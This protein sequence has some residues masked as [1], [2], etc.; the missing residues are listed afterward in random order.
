MARLVGLQA[1]TPNAPYIG[2]WTR[3]YGFARADLADLIA[4]REVVRATLLRS[5]L[6]LTTAADYLLFRPALQPALT[7]ALHATFRQRARQLDLGRLLPAALSYLEAAPRRLTALRVWSA[8]LMPTE[9]AEA[10]VSAVARAYLPLVQVF[11]GGVW[12]RATGAYAPAE[13]W[14]GAALAALEEGVRQLILRHLAAFGP[15]S[16]ADVEQWSG[17]RQLGRPLA[18]LGPA[19]REFRD[20]R[21]VA[22]FDLPDA[23]RLPAT[24]PAPPRFLPEYDNLLLAHVDRTRVVADEQRPRIFLSARGFARHSWSMAS[25]AALGASSA[26]TARSPS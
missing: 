8:E 3:L 14:L 23:P 25:C 15:A 13:S 6:H 12:G 26:A 18:A 2:L 17:L 5:T 11:P 16:V 20:E 10:M 9:D 24:T 22:L 7:R 21:G 19:L 4:Q 1:Q